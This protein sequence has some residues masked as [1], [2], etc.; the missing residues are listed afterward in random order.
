VDVREPDLGQEVTYQAI[1]PYGAPP[2]G[3][4]TSQGPIW[5]SDGQPWR[6]AGVSAFKLCDRFRRGEDIDPFLA[7]YQGF[8]LLRVWD[9]TPASAWGA[10]AWD[11]APPAVWSG[12]LAYVAARGWRVELTLLTDDDPARLA[13]AQQLVEALFDAQPTNLLLEAGNEPETHKAIDTAALRGT[14]EASG[15]PYVSG[16]YEDSD[17]WYGSYYVDHSARDSE[18]PRRAH[19]LLEFYAGDGPDKPTHPHHVPCV[20]DEPAKWQDVSFRPTDWRA[21]FGVCALLG[22]GGTFHSETGKLGQPPTTDEMALAA[23]ALGALRAFPADAPLGPYR[24]I[25][26]DSLRTYVVGNHMVRV[27]PTTRTA[28]ESGWRMLD[29]DGILWSR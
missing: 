25:V 23:E 10:A 3:R 2:I 22:A 13:P 1:R 20:E 11:S 24:R 9:Y 12:F 15:F 18:W 4:L 7:A 14:L 28:P 5:L 29:G 21:Y 27:R 16:N 26:D 6:W 8:N 19:N 17:R